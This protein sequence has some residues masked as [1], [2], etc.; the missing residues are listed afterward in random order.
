MRGS[1]TLERWFLGEPRKAMPEF[2]V[3]IAWFYLDEAKLK[4]VA[5]QA[6]ACARK[7]VEEPKAV[8]I[9]DEDVNAA[10]ERGRLARGEPTPRPEDAEEEAQG[11]LAPVAEGE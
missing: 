2:R 10:R 5:E 1:S 11:E 4:K 8:E 9:V 7:L 3:A 6:R